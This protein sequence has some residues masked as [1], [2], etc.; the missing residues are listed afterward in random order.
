MFRRVH[1]GLTELKKQVE[2][3]NGTKNGLLQT[4]SIEG[5][6]TFQCYFFN[7][8]L[9]G[10]CLEFDGVT[11][12]ISNYSRG[13][14]NGARRRYEASSMTLQISDYLNNKKNGDSLLF[15]ENGVLL[16]HLK[17]KDDKLHGE[18][19][20]YHKGK[21]HCISNFKDGLQHGDY[22]IY[23]LLGFEDKIEARAKYKNNKLISWQKYD[24]DGKM[25]DDK[26]PVFRA[27]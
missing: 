13:M 23:F 27:F 4:Y 8:K 21:I 17:Y 11:T 12:T 26:S 5:Y 10:E 25:I 6:L 1:C 18:C 20:E 24:F 22:I 16:Q 9:H 7:N 15:T 2:Y 19:K 14:L 3:Y